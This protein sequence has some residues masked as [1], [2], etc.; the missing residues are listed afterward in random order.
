LT[1]KL[2]ATVKGPLAEPIVVFEEMTQS[3]DELHNWARSMETAQAGV[4][5]PKNSQET[6]L[7]PNFLSIIDASLFLHLID[8]F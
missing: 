2:P 7:T 3:P 1:V 6:M 8:K 4:A 5:A